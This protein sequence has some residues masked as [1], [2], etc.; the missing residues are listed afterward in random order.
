MPRAGDPGRTGSGRGGAGTG[1][2]VHARHGTERFDAR[3]QGMLSE[4]D[5]MRG[6]G[7]GQPAQKGGASLSATEALLRRRVRTLGHR[8][9]TV[10]SR[11]SPRAWHHL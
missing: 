2:W 8:P 7:D 10:V 1:T 3:A 5:I 11:V 6:F 9:G 4:Q